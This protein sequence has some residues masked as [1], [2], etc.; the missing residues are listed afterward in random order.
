MMNAQFTPFPELVTE[1][2]FLRAIKPSDK[3][4]LFLLRSDDNVNKHIGR[5]K[6]LSPDDVQA[7]MDKIERGIKENEWILWVIIL[8]ENREVV[9]TICLWNLSM[10]NNSAEIGYEL[11]PLYQKKGIM[12]EAISAVVGYGFTNMHA[13]TIEACPRIANTSSVKLLESFDFKRDVAL[14]YKFSDDQKRIG[15]VMYTLRNPR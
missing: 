2:L 11:L 5:P 9:G 15:M 12:R 14:E 1:R 3:M 4:P 8:K 10:E 6:A 7:Y 13:H